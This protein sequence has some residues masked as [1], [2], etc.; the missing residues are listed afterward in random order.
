MNF[1]ITTFIFCGLFIIFCINGSEK[2]SPGNNYTQD[3]LNAHLIKVVEKNHFHSAEKLIN[4]G[5][6]VN[7]IVTKKVAFT[8]HPGKIPSSTPMTLLQDACRT[9]NTS[10]AK[11]LLAHPDIDPNKTTPEYTQSPLSL[12]LLNANNI[13][14][15]LINHEKV[16][17]VVESGNSF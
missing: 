3:L 6:C 12:N 1:K 16:N 9:N 13:T 11:L 8:S 4:V 17:M 15:I 5:A 14:E 7:S 10:F 2:K